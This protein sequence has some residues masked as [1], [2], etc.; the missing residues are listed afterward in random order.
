MFLFDLKLKI[1]TNYESL[2]TMR[3][4]KSNIIWIK[5]GRILSIFYRQH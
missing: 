1:L 5:S 4:M 2:K 3:R